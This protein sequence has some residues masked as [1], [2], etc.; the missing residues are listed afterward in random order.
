MSRL[1]LKRKKLLPPAHKAW[2][3]I[4]GGFLS[5]INKLKSSALVRRI[6]SAAILTI[7]SFRP[8]LPFNSGHRCRP[9]IPR[10]FHPSSTRHASYYGYGH[11]LQKNSYSPI[12][13]DELFDRRERAKEKACGSV[14][15]A[16]GECSGIDKDKGG[17]EMSCDIEERW[18]TIVSKSPQLRCVDERAEEFIDKFKEEM[19]LERERSML[20]F[21][22]M[23]RRGA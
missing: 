15:S 9:L 21:Q 13:I 11:Q 23:L 8:S 19:K 10:T 7:R 3:V 2:K 22:E 5:Q 17:D 14:T 1:S 16:R 12:Y 20:E 6:V 18:R 4:S